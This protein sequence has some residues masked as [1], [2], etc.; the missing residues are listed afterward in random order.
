MTV[1]RCSLDASP[2]VIRLWSCKVECISTVDKPKS[3]HHFFTA[4]W[5][6]SAYKLP[7]CWSSPGFDVVLHFPYH[8]LTF[9]AL[10]EC[11]GHDR[12][13]ARNSDALA[14]RQGKEAWQQ[15]KAGRFGIIDLSDAVTHEE[16]KGVVFTSQNLVG[17]WRGM[18]FNTDS[19]F[20]SR[21]NRKPGKG[22]RRTAPEAC[23][24]DCSC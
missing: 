7:G 5:T 2:E 17:H 14:C 10:C 6:G 8:P 9:P 21:G 4:F 1:Q 23:G 12:V 13:H 16:L 20:R 15:W 24:I 19:L 11:L 22:K 18:L 3:V